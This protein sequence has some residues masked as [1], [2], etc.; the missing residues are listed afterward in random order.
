MLRKKVGILLIVVGI[1]LFS[2]YPIMD[3]LVTPFMINKLHSEML[4][5]DA[6]TY[7]KNQAREIEISYD[8][9]SVE[10]LP[11]LTTELELDP[12]L[13]IGEILIPSV[14]IHLPIVKGTNN[15]SLRLGIGTMKKDQEMGK[16]NY[17]LAGHNS[18]NPAQFFAPLRKVSRDDY[19]YL[20]DKQHMYTYQVDTIEIVSPDRIDVIFDQEE[21]EARITLVSCYSHDGSDR[22]VVQGKLV[23]QTPYDEDWEK[24]I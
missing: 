2:L 21:Q 24:E 20:T 5:M 16:G 11:L 3:Y 1:F 23:S 10:N 7:A 15:Q 13:V 12:N 18:R 4:A 19:I 8:F 6:E 14:D 17:A 9:D 22:I